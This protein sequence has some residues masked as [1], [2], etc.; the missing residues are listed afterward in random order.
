MPRFEKG[1]PAGP[2]RPP[3][4]CNKATVWLDELAREGTEQL[5]KNV[6]EQATAGDL[7]AAAIVL[8]RTWPRR[9]GALVKLDLPPAVKVSRIGPTQ[10]L[11]Q[12]IASGEIDALHTARAPSTFYSQPDKVKRLFPDFMAVERD[13]YR[14]TKIFPKRIALVFRAKS[15]ATLQFRNDRIN[16]VLQR[17]RK[18][19]R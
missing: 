11:S 19:R 15:L 13:Y 7:R 18:S 2:G 3:G 17:A 4:C 10:T 9:R 8:S 1:D 12:M 6:T 5:V 14:K 16:E